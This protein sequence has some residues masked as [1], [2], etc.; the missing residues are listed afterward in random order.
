MT[1]KQVFEKFVPE[2]AVDYCNQLYE[3]LEFEFKIT[4][5]RA[6]KLGDFRFKPDHKKSVITINN[7][8]NPYAFLITYLH[9]VAHLTTFQ[10]FNRKVAPHGKEWKQEFVRLAQPMLSSDIFP[11]NVLASLTRYFKQ[12][13]ASSCSDP[14]LYAALRQ[15]DKPTNKIPLNKIQNKEPFRLNKKQ[16]IRLEKKRTRWLCEEIST[17][18][19]YL[20]SGVAEVELL[21]VNS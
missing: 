8:L 17:K 7:D 10:E 9:E 13:K 12:P 6:T 16:F 14:Q 20:I 11:P 4:K 15:F 5:S 18:R 1:S 19:K 21:E 2:G 3:N